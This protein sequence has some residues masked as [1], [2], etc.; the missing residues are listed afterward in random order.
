MLLPADSGNEQV[1]DCANMPFIQIV[2][3]LSMAIDGSHMCE[4]WVVESLDDNGC[5]RFH[6]KTECFNCTR[7]CIA[8]FNESQVSCCVN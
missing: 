3:S 1:S 4:H 6:V 7:Y 5:C 2:Q 8:F